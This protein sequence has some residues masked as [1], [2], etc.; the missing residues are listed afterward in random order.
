MLH[1]ESDVDILIVPT[2]VHCAS[3]GTTQIIG[4]DIF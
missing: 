4:E 2:A 3:K 1:D